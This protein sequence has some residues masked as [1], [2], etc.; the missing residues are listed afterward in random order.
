[1]KQVL[2]FLDAKTKNRSI[3][4]TVS[5]VLLDLTDLTAVYQKDSVV[6]ATLVPFELPLY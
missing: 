6:F 3:L 4:L 2:L 1:M 5:T